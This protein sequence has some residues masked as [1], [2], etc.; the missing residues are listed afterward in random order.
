MK[1]VAID[2][3][4]QADMRN[5]RFVGRQKKIKSKSRQCIVL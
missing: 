1:V 4:A 2:A 3:E 5:Q